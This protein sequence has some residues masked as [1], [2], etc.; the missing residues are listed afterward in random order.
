MPWKALK[1]VGH[2]GAPLSSTAKRTEPTRDPKKQR[3]P[4][5]MAKI[6]QNCPEL[7]NCQK[8]SK[9]SK[10]CLNMK[11]TQL[12]KIKNY[13]GSGIYICLAPMKKLTQRRLPIAISGIFISPINAKL[14]FC[15]WKLLMVQTRSNQLVP[16]GLLI[17]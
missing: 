7:S 5:T 12:M 3:Q 14:S 6:V 10:N 17:E 16:I 4:P 8:L 9:I 13:Q 11:V 15:C 1:L 2:M